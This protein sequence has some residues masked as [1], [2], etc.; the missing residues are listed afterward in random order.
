MTLEPNLLL[1]PMLAIS[2]PQWAVAL[3]VVGFLFI[4]VVMVLIV[5]IQRPQGGGLSGAFG[6]GG[7]S[8]GQT[9][10]GARTG[11]AL[12]ISTITVF[13]LYLLAAIFLNYTIAPPVVSEN[14]QLTAAAQTTEGEADKSTTFT[15]L[16]PVVVGTPDDAAAPEADPNDPLGPL[17]ESPPEQTP[18]PGEDTPPP[19]E[20][21]ATDTPSDG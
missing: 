13:I 7:G 19:G 10:F 14:P 1:T 6:A 11:D 20:G 16:P 12:T 3:L 17:P 9:A 2:L 5:L 21:E 8:A 18:S 15:E 4:S